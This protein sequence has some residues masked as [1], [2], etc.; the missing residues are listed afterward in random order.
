M[1]K[2]AYVQANKEWLMEKYNEQGVVKLDKGVCYKVL[3]KGNGDGPVP[4]PRSIVTVHYTGRTID[5]NTFDSSRGGVP[6]AIR[7]SDLIEGW[8]IALQ[9]MHVGDRWEIYIFRPKWGMAGSRSRAF[10]PVLLWCLMSN[11]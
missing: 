2:K 7:L 5:G 10:L 6:L 11:C 3:S 9:Q 8:I 1:S 4:S